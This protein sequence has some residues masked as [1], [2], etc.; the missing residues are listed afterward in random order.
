MGPGTGQ[1]GAAFVWNSI[2]DPA[3]NAIQVE[4][5]GA[6]SSSDQ[7]AAITTQNLNPATGTPT[8]GSF[9]QISCYGLSTLSIQTVGVYTGVL[10]LQVTI[11]GVNWI[12]LG[13]VAIVNVNTG[14]NSATIPSAAQSIYQADVSG[15][16]MAR[17]S[18]NAS[19]TGSVQVTLSLAED[20]AMVS[21][22]ASL[23]AG[24][25][26]IGATVLGTTTTVSSSNTT[27]A[28]TTNA[29]SVKTT[30]GKIG[31]LS[32]T[33][34]AAYTTFFKL[35]NKASA[36]TVGTDIPLLTIPVAATSFLPIGSGVNGDYYSTGI[37]FA[38]TKLMPDTDTTV[39]V[40]GDL[41]QHMTYV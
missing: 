41:K 35:Y 39:L 8:P 26:V 7:T 2:Y 31:N 37:A 12:S 29:T 13:G 30:A 28:A 20:P 1:Y 19:V 9:V 11:D 25:N 27:A 33:C 15:F 34:Y 3:N 38:M 23:P 10:T 24:A 17:I 40:A 4:A 21:L 16:N 5:L 6:S 32:L 14:A 36:P 18:A 22:D